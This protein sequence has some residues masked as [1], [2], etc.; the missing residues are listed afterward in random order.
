MSLRASEIVSDRL[1]DI[2]V[3]SDGVVKSR[4]IDQ[5]DSPPVEKKRGRLHV[6]GATFERIA[7]GQV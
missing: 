6:D 7:D 5:G 2:G 4:S 1:Q 3:A